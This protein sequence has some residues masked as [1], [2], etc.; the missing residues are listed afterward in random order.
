M[1]RYLKF[2]VKHRCL[3]CLDVGAIKN[4]VTAESHEVARVIQ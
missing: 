1:L 3:P 2:V 4:A